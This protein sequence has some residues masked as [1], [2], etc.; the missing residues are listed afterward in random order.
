MKT[1]SN[2]HKTLCLKEGTTAKFHPPTHT[3][4]ERAKKIEKNSHN[5]NIFNGKNLSDHTPAT[6]FY[7]IKAKPILKDADLRVAT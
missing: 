2:V 7:Q 5:N 1:N 4:Y 3:Y 6:N